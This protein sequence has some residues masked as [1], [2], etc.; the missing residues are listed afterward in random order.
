[1]KL[2]SVISSLVLVLGFASSGLAPAAA[3]R[4]KDGTVMRGEFTLKDGKVLKGEVVRML[5]DAYVIESPNP[6]SAGIKDTN[7]VPKADVVKMVLEKPDEKPFLDEI[8]KLV[9]TPDFL[10]VEEYK[11]RIQAVKAFL[12]KYPNGSRAKDA[13]E[14]LKTLSDECADVEAGGRK[15]GGLMIKPAEYKANAFD[16]DARVLE[17]KILNAASNGQAL[18]ALR[19]FADLDKD[20]QTAAC[21]REVLPVVRNVLK[22]V[23]DAIKLRVDDYD[24]RMEKREADLAAASPEEREK[25][26][27]AIDQTTAK[28][29]KTYQQEKSSGQTWFSWNQ[30]YKQ[31]MDDDLSLAESELQRLSTTPPPAADGGKIYRN[32]WKFIHTDVDAETMEKALANAEAAA[33]PERYLKMLRDAAAATG[34]KRKED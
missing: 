32:T 18:T 33:L 26:K 22:S 5:G 10:T 7:I 34:V 2:P 21:Y 3:I 15:V 29:E 14:I 6:K 16:L 19:A 24:A 27:R 23:R 28:W 31:A 4:L 1:M 17:T 8:A 30:D 9:P 13:A 11:Q 20:Y 25:N 12:A